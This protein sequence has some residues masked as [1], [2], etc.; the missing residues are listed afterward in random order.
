LAQLGFILGERG[1]Y[2]EAEQSLRRAI[3]LGD[4]H[5]YAHYDLGRLL[6]KTR[7][8]EEAIPILQR[9]AALKADNPDVHYQ[10]FMALT[11]VKRKDEAD[12]EMALFKKLDEERKRR[13]KEGGG[14]HGYVQGL[15]PPLPSPTPAENLT[16]KAP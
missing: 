5:F 13:E 7:R 8:F 16:P 12:R 14:Q 1:V 6:V 15:L 4:K 2:A 9:G 3:A 11:R 10:L